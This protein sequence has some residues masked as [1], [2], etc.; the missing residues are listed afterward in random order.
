MILWVCFYDLFFNFNC[1][2]LMSWFVVIWFFLVVFSVIF[3]VLEYGSLEGSLMFFVNRWIFWVCKKF[4]FLIFVILV[5][6]MII[7]FLFVLNNLVM[8]EFFFWILIWSVLLLVLRMLCEVLIFY[9]FL[10]K[11]G[12]K[13]VCGV[14]LEIGGG[15][16]WGCGFGLVW[17]WFLF[18][19][20]SELIVVLMLLVCWNWCFGFFFNVCI[21]IVLIWGFIGVCCD[22]GLKWLI[23]NLF[24]SNL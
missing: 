24:V 20:L 7:L 5:M 19:W 2:C 12:I 23:G 4:L 13:I 1:S 6:G 15:V 16:L 21:M 17:W 10:M 11:K 8:L 3:F 9:L 18:L 22:G 14:G